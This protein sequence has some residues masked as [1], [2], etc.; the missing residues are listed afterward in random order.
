[1]EWH[2]QNHGKSQS[3]IA[4]VIRVCRT[5][6][7]G[8]ILS[9]N[10]EIWEF[11]NG[12]M[13][14]FIPAGGWF[15]QMIQWIQNFDKFLGFANFFTCYLRKQSLLG[16]SCQ[17]SFLYHK[18]AEFWLKITRFWFLVTRMADFSWK[19]CA[20]ADFYPTDDTHL[21]RHVPI[22]IQW[23]LSRRRFVFADNTIGT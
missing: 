7:S 16:F 15:L 8:N 19:L 1:M 9:W 17:Q 11:F 5:A 14:F 3:L 2:S 13:E 23:Q 20:T 4:G 21:I 10:T 12:A 22:C 6:E 18:G